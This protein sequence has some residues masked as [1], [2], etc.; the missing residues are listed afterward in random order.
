MNGTDQGTSQFTAAIDQGTTS[1][2]FFI[3]D[4]RGEPVAKHQEEFAQIYPHAGWIEHDPYVLIQSVRNCIEV[5]TAK[6]LAEGY[7][8]K[9]IRAIGITNQR[10][11]SVIWDV[12]NGKA[13]HNAIVWADSRTA[14]IVRQLKLKDGADKVLEMTGLPLS[15]YPSAVKVKWILEHCK[16]AREVYDEGYLA[17]GTV[18]SW[19]LYNLVIGESGEKLHVTDV[20]NASR[21]M[22]LHI[23]TLDY[24]PFLKSFFGLEKLLLPKLASS[25]NSIAYGTM[26]SGPLKGLRVTGCLGDQSAAL[27]GQKAF[28]QGMAK[29]TYGTGCF[30]LYNTGNKPVIS[31]NG[32]LTTVAFQLEN[33]KPVYAL[34]GSIAVAGS[35]V[36]FLRDNLGIIKEAR[37]VGD[38]AVRVPDSGGVVFVT[39]FAGL[40]APYWIDDAQG[41]I[42]GMTNYTTK[43]HIC[44]ATVE[45][46]CFQTKAIIIAMEKDSGIKIKN[47]AVDGG[48]SNSDECMQ[49]QSDIIGIDVDRPAMRETTALGAAIAAGFGARIWSSFSDLG[50]VNARNHKR[51]TT[52][53]T[54]AQQTSQFRRWERA[55]AMSKGWLTSEDIDQEYD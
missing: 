39:A 46:T 1:T 33:S 4:E 47:L 6:F 37:E 11:T 52:K 24:D 8:P 45:A 49:M 30:M 50:G 53:T 20:T 51:F 15:T 42:F 17:F 14:H 41:T 32:L 36:K 48:M 10:E 29:N 3:F 54:K 19:L 26:E 28:D 55:V 5:A 25:S 2:R 18:D 35:A 40:F 38:L 12:R 13:L 34:E 31:K 9:D 43:E 44:R 16:A 27:V 7:Q 22:L 21:T 23:D